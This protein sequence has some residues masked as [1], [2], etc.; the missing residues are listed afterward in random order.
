MQTDLL[1]LIIIILILFLGYYN[2][3]LWLLKK[4][5]PSQFYVQPNGFN[6]N[7]TTPP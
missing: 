3:H 7:L 6:E 1:H 2:S 4:L 5:M